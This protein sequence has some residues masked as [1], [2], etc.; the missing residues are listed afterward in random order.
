MKLFFAMIF[1]VF[2]IL[3]LSAM[4]NEVSLLQNNYKH[5]VCLLENPP[6]N[7]QEVCLKEEKKFFIQFYQQFIEHYSQQAKDDY[8][9]INNS[10][11]EEIKESA[12][13]EFFKMMVKFR[14]GSLRFA[15]AKNERDELLG[16]CFFYPYVTQV[17]I[18]SLFIQDIHDDNLFQKVYTGMISVIQKTFPATTSIIIFK[19]TIPDSKIETLLSYGFS[20]MSLEFYEFDFPKKRTWR[21]EAYQKNLSTYER[22][23][24]I[25]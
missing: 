1:F 4:N 8:C 18:Q 17:I 9:G 3:S 12:G 19:R 22:W 20:F 14:N 7:K 21:V 10:T 11:Q 6:L 24:N 15:S 25:L 2:F 23:C 16:G 5:V 13:K